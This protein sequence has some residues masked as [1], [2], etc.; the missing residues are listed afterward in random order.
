M[1]TET[2]VIFDERLRSLLS[3]MA[4]EGVSYAAR[5]FSD[6]VG[7]TL[8]V[9]R[10]QVDL[11]PLAGVPNLLG[12]PESEAVGIYLRVQGEMSGQIMLVLAYPKALELV[13][14]IMNDP[15]GT[16]RSLGALER[17]ALAELGNLTGTFFLNAVAAYTG[18]GARPSPPAIMVDMVGAILDIVVAT[19]GAVSQNVLLLKASFLN[20]GRE[21]QADFWVIP[22]P[23][24][25]E[26]FAKRNSV[27]GC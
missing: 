9:S 14:L 15:P 1:M 4:Q 22:D 7:Q 24:A 13:D 2:T 16:T 10:P 23:A 12:G 6:M 26:A 3:V 25:L 20:E 19:H 21:V 27:H 18:F 5:G 17:S 11:M 8:G